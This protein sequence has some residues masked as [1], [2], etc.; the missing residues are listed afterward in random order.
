M[1][2]L[3]RTAGARKRCR[4]RLVQPDGQQRQRAQRSL[5]TARVSAGGGL[6]CQ[7]DAPSYPNVAMENTYYDCGGKRSR[8]ALARKARLQGG[9][10]VINEVTKAIDQLMEMGT[11]VIL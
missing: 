5:C 2:W 10:A 1:G 9:Q 11:K 3:D 8:S 7:D 6:V 4:P